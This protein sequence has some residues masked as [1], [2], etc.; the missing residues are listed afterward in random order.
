M[1]EI[2]YKPPF[3]SDKKNYE[4]DIFI[5]D[6]NTGVKLLVSIEELK[7]DTSFHGMY[8]YEGISGNR[9][10]AEYLKEQKLLYK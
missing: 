5:Y 9:T 8:V 3:I 2:G 7:N 10:V 6:K 1:T 4:P